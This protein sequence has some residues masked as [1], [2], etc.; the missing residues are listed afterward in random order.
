MFRALLFALLLAGSMLSVAA[1]TAPD[2]PAPVLRLQGS[3]TINAQLGPR[4][5]EGLMREQGLQQIQT[6]ASA[7]ANEQRVTGQDID[8]SI[9]QAQV[10][11]HGSS[12]GF[13]ALQGGLTDVAASSR[14][15]K[16]QELLA[17]ASL[18]DLRSPQAEH[19]I[20]IDGVAVIVHPGNPL[21]QLD[22]QT[23]ARIFSGEISDWQT[24]GGTP[25]RIVL[26]AR[27]EQSGTWETF[28]ELVL[29]AHAKALSA[30]ARRLESSE[31]LADE[32]SRTPNAIGF[33]GLPWVRRA[34]ALAIADGDAQPLLPTIESIATEDYPLTRRLYLYLPPHLQNPWAQALVRFAQS[35]QGQAI[36]AASGFVAQ[37][38]QTIQT[39]PD[40]QMSSQYQALSRHAQRLSVNFRFEQGSA[41]LDN[42]ALFDVQ[43]LVDYLSAH[44]KLDRQV[45]L[46]GFGDAK[47]DPQRALLLSRLRAMAVRRELLRHDVILRDV[48]GQGED[49][50]VADDDTAQG[51]IRNRRVEVWVH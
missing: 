6:R 44:D 43:R 30:G 5:I 25:G 23:L 16:H 7:V 17:L 45:T 22:T 19:V 28:R 26:Y 1:Q 48:L 8:A 9:W 27:D 39:R 40:L 29:T 36:V 38:I 35:R 12:T 3:N 32:V 15:I 14:P 47:D 18:G 4:L 31:Q 33:I 11:A 13:K 21:R 50:P 20:G 37:Q 2:S 41:R 51:R 49:M 42:K 34:R 46:V 10:A 24:I